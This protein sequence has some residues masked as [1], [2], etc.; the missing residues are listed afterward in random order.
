MNDTQPDAR[1]S[2]LARSTVQVCLGQVSLGVD[3]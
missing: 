1:S 2:Q 3:G